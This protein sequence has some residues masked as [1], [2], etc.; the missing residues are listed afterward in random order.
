MNFRTLCRDEPEINLIPFIDVLLVV[1]IFLMLTTT[2]SKFT[3]LQ[4]TLPVADAEQQRDRPREVIVS[5]AANGRYAV[6]QTG[7]DGRSLEA[8]VQALRSATPAGR[9]SVLII[10]ADAM[11]SHQSV[12][13]VMEAARRLGLAQIT[14][15]TQS[16]ASARASGR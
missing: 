9:D 13:T 4:L 5:V 14:F 7:V 10:S 11:A 1:L 8:I 15:A 3:Q 2:Y 16:S 12:V 6:N